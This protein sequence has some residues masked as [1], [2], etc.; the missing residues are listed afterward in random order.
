[1]RPIAQI[2]VEGQSAMFNC[3]LIKT[4]IRWFHN[5]VPINDGEHDI[6]S[7]ILFMNDIQPK[8]HGNYTCGYSNETLAIN[9]SGAL[10]VLGMFIINWSIN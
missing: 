5:D 7:Q 8:H 3:I 1:M 9:D 6:V 10:G 4:K 2:V